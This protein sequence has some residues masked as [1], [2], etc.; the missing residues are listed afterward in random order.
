MFANKLQPYFNL[1][2]VLNQIIITYTF[3]KCE[4]CDKY[5][6]DDFPQ[7][8]KNMPQVIPAAHCMPGHFATF[9][10]ILMLLLASSPTC[11]RTDLMI[12]RWH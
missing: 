7:E 11:M 8:C 2:P 10:C 12:I 6:L 4:D 1:P 3:H 5:L 9:F